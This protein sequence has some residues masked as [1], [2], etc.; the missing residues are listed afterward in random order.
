MSKVVN[1]KQ[2]PKEQVTRYQE[3]HPIY[4]DLDEKEQLKLMRQVIRDQREIELLQQKFKADKKD[5]DGKIEKLR[6]KISEAYTVIRDAKQERMILCEWRF[7]W[8]KS[9]KE[10]V[11]MDTE[12]PIEILPIQEHERQMKL[13][14]EKD[15]ENE[16]RAEEEEA[17]KKE[18]G[19]GKNGGKVKNK[20]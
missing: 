10:L 20:K 9:E 17:A 16:Q 5:Y 11:R 13:Q 8:D 3:E 18:N 14:E 15:R 6:A 19:K 12:E 2:N 1:M 4:V 7:Y